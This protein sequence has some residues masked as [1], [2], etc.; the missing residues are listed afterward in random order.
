[1]ITES[2]I[3]DKKTLENYVESFDFGDMVIVVEGSRGSG[4]L[5]PRD[6]LLSNRNVS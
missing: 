5:I 4:L 3:Q 1:M 2:L 6:R